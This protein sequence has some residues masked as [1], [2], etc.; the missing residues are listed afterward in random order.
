MKK[1]G[2]FL[3]VYALEQIGV[4]RTFGI[5]GVHNTEIYDALSQSDKITPY[6]VT[7]EVC[8]TFGVPFQEKGRTNPGLIMNI[9]FFSFHPLD[10]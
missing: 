8:A 2:A 6:L 9:D 10:T 1:T 7:H 3:T 5:P 4:E